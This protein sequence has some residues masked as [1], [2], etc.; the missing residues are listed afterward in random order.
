MKVLGI[1]PARKGSKR[2]PNK[3]HFEL[4]GKPMFAYTIEAALQ[5]KL[6]D[7]VVISSNDLEL[8][9][10]A[11]NYDI[12][13]FERPAELST[14]TAAIDDAFRHVCRHLY[15]RDGYKPDIVIAMQGN[16]P[17]RKEGQ[18]DEVIKRFK[19]L[20]D[21]TAICTALEGRL[22]P[23]WAK[24]IKDQSTGEVA[25]YLTGYTGYR[26]Q[27]Y[28]KLYSMDGAI[29]GIRQSTLF[30]QEGKKTLHAWLGERLHIIVQEHPMYSLEIDNPDEVQLAFHYLLY[31]RYGD[32]LNEKLSGVL[33]DEF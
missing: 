5:A 6:L 2:F 9:K 24:V 15:D 18:I 19:E 11:E 14:A 8:K 22:R 25:Q 13:F 21:A 27:D 17:I 32:K 31:Q 10:I 23:E 33:S 3:H 20:P 26:K 30:E 29:Y 4:L 16:V 7:R 1:I 28:P 12:E